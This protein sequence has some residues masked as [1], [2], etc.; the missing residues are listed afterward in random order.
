MNYFFSDAHAF[1]TN[2]C[3][4]TSNW[5]DKELR[6]RNFNTIE[7]MN[8]AIIK[9][10]NS[11]VGEDDTLYHLGDWSFGGWENIWNFRKQIVCKNIININGN[12][13]C[14][15]VENTEILTEYGWM[16]FDMWNILRPKI[17]SYNIKTGKVEFDFCIDFHHSYYNGEMYNIKN[18]LID[19]RVTPNH[20]LYISQKSNSDKNF[21]F[22]EC[23]N[24]KENKSPI[25]FKTESYNYNSDLNI[26][27][28]IIKLLAWILSDGTV[29][30]SLYGV[31]YVLYQSEGKNL[32]IENLLKELGIDF[33]KN[34]RNRNI[35]KI[36][37]KELKSIKT[38]YEYYIKQGSVLENYI[39]SKYTFPK[40]LYNL[41]KRQFMVFL[42]SYVLADGNRHKQNPDT[43]WVIYGMEKQLSEIQSLCFLNG[44][45]SILNIY[46]GKQYRLYVTLSAKNSE[47]S[48]YSDSLKKEN[49]KG[50]IFCFKTKNDTLVVR[51]NGKICVTGNSH[52]KNNKFFPH[53]EKQ[54][55]IIYEIADKENYRSWT[56]SKKD[57]DVTAKD[58]FKEVYN[59]TGNSGIEINIEGQK[60]ILNHYPLKSWKDIENGSWLLSGHEHGN[61]KDIEKGK[62][63]DIGWC[64][65][66][67][68]LSFLEIK[69]IMDSRKIEL[70]LFDRS[71]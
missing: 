33:K 19:L 53:L 3:R 69:E 54:G 42:E 13:D 43:S 70:N 67:K 5:E 35:S 11:V 44:I 39:T 46:R 22:I 6:C 15:D 45:R 47:I 20:R 10:I 14:F 29:K 66:K 1:H 61:F 7:E 51:R 27:D 25:V 71:H 8:S 68:P 59:G 62:M 57:G 17:A 30:E 64:R 16:R 37:G 41:S 58:F 9:S 4:G 18:R 34:V 52:I 65:F 49:Y 2:I 63:L 60:I 21:K 48:R 40:W 24:I 38:T 31:S 55:D 56:G 26:N 32:I 28:S 50:Y 12:H 23:Q 36:T